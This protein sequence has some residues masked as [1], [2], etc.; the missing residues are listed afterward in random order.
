[1][2][3]AAAASLLVG[4][5]SLAFVLFQMWEGV[6]EGGESALLFGGVWLVFS[7]VAT[8]LCVVAL[9]RRTPFRKI[10]LGIIVVTWLPLLVLAIASLKES[11]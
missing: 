1:M 6:Y 11:S 4:L 3:K 2:L 7:I 5:L 10:A 8:L 9:V